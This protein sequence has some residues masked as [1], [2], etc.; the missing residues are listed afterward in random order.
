M[1]SWSTE[2]AGARPSARSAVGPLMVAAAR[3]P[4]LPRPRTAERIRCLP[5]SRGPTGW[6]GV[7]AA[8][9]AG[10]VGPPTS[11]LRGSPKAMRRFHD[12]AD[13]RGSVARGPAQAAEALVGVRC[14]PQGSPAAALD[15]VPRVYTQQLRCQQLAMGDGISHR[16]DRAAAAAG[17]ARLE[18]RT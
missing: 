15:A 11:A 8:G 14:P 13:P 12:G 3:S 16:L 5:G 18:A 7:Q 6:I 9:A 1:P 2:S 10:A 4:L 17:A